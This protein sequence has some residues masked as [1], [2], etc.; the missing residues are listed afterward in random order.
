MSFTREELIEAYNY[1]SFSRKYSLIFEEY[2]LKGVIP[3]FVHLGLGAEGLAAGLFTELRENDWMMPWLRAQSMLAKRIGPFEYLSEMF[4]KKTGANGGKAGEA[5]SFSRKHRCGPYSGLIG[6][7][8]SIATGI[9][10]AMKMDKVDGCVVSSVGDGCI[11]EGLISESLNIIATWKLPVVSVIENNGIALST[12]PQNSSA[13]Y[14][15]SE[16]AKGFGLPGSSYDGTDV[17]LVKEVMR[18]A[19]A[20]ARRCEPSLIEFRIN[21]WSGHFVGDPDVCRDPRTVADAKVNRDPH[22]WNRNF[23]ISQNVAAEEEPD[24]ID[25]A[26]ETEIREAITLAMKQEGNSKENILNSPVYADAYNN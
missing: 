23:L 9:A 10:F 2:A 8:S 3:G 5:H 14:D 1:V 16:R 12:S 22:K 4:A 26:N 18:E 6:A 24:A 19:M 7:G 25:A 17:L 21:R 20:K 11:N 13:I 15:L